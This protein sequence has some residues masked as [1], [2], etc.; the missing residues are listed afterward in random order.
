MRNR[1]IKLSNNQI[2]G[3]FVMVI[4]LCLVVGIGCMYCYVLIS[5]IGEYLGFSKNVHI[6]VNNIINKFPTII[7]TN[8]LSI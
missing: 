6:D 1:M 5:S 7:N 4:G 3:F 8:S 2:F